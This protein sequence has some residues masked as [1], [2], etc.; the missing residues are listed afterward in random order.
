MSTVPWEKS[1]AGALAKSAKHIEKQN[2]KFEK[3]TRL[4]K[5][6][7]IAKD[8]IKLIK[9][10]VEAKHGTYLDSDRYFTQDVRNSDEE[11]AQVL[12]KIPTCRACAIGTV[13]LACVLREDNFS[14]A[15]LFDGGWESSSFRSFDQRM[16][17][18]TSKH[19][20]FSRKEMR[21]MEKVFEA[22][23]YDKYAPNG[24]Y[25]YIRPEERLTLLM[26]QIINRKGKDFSKSMAMATL[27]KI[28]KI[29]VK[30]VKK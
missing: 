5:R 8:V 2:E 3:M 18:Y 23:G 4:E 6:V 24:Y 7:H 17:D 22:Q 25:S 27:N 11:L 30:A 14:S 1:I 29:R 19:K 12:G 15:K 21:D 20:L 10:K 13:F 16:V 26:K 28:V 9:G